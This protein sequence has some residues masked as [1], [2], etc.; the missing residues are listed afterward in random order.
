MFI[1]VQTIT[2]KLSLTSLQYCNILTGL[3]ERW[4]SGSLLIWNICRRTS[5]S[6]KFQWLP[7]QLSTVWN[8]LWQTSRICRL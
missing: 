8:Y 6:W 2:D 7:S 3:G 5:Y 1:S 4:S